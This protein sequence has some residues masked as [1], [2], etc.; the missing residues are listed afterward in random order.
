MSMYPSI[1]VCNQVERRAYY[2]GYVDWYAAHA[3]VPVLGYDF[4]FRLIGLDASK[5]AAMFG[6]S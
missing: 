4:N 2:A 3:Y 6:S 5:K 1:F